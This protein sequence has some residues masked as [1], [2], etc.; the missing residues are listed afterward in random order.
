[1][2]K[3][4]VSVVEYIEN[5]KTCDSNKHIWS[6]YIGR[7]SLKYVGKCLECKMVVTGDELHEIIKNLDKYERKLNG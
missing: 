6:H 1:M 5:N 3:E 7:N 2:G 4:R